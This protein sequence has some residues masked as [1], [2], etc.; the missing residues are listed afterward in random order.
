MGKEDREIVR[1]VLESGDEDAQRAYA[2]LVD[3][4][5]LRVFR[6]AFR[7][8]RN[9]HD[10]EDVA[11]E[12]FLRAWRFLPRLRDPDRFGPWLYRIT[13]N[14]AR[15]LLKERGL[16]S[17]QSAVGGLIDEHEAHVSPESVRADLRDAMARVPAGL[18]QVLRDK[19]EARLTYDEIAEREEI[20]VWTVKDRLKKARVELERVL[21]ATGYLG[22]LTRTVRT[23]GSHAADADVGGPGDPWLVPASETTGE[24]GEL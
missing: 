8:V 7:F 3:R 15:N 23:A 20:S 19:Y 1:E 12:S 10:A 9:E 17:Q 22:E 11:S 24:R 13:G 5:K 16:R 6:Y 4:W 18:V 14:V 2:H 21:E